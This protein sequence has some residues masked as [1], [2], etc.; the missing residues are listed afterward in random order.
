[1]GRSV[2]NE[3]IMVTNAVVGTDG[4]TR[5]APLVATCGGAAGEANCAAISPK[6]NSARYVVVE[7]SSLTGEY[8]SHAFYV[9]VTK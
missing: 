8:T 7:T 3:S 2:A 5:G 9:Q 6:F 1:M 4:D